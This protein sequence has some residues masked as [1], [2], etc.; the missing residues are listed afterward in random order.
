MMLNEYNDSERELVETLEHYF[1]DNSLYTKTNSQQI[2]M[3][4]KLTIKTKQ[5]DLKKIRFI[6]TL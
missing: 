2:A 5:N 6:F 4:T 1:A 3:N